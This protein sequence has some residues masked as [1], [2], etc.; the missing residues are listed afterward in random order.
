MLTNFGNWFLGMLR[1]P[2]GEMWVASQAE[3]QHYVNGSITTYDQG[4]TPWG[5]VRDFRMDLDPSGQLWGITTSNELMLFDGQSYPT[6][7]LDSLGFEPDTTS[8]MAIDDN[9]DLYI[10]NRSGVAQFSLPTN[11]ALADTVWPGDANDDLIANHMDFL[12]LGMAFG[13]SGPARPN[14]TIN[15]QAEPATTW[16]STLPN[17]AN[18]VHCDTDGDGVVDYSDTLAILNNYGLTHNKSGGI[19]QSGATPL[20]IVPDFSTYQAGDTVD[21]PIILGIDT[22]TADSVYGLAFTISYD[23][24]LVDSASVQVDFGNSWLGDKNQD[25]LSM[26]RDDFN[27]GQVEIALTRNDQVER[28]GFGQIAKI[29]VIMIDDVS[30]KDLI[31]DTLRMEISNVRLIRRDDTDIPYDTEIAEIEVTQE[32]TSL[33]DLGAEDWLIFPNPAQDMLIVEAKRSAKRQSNIR[34]YNLQGQ[35]LLQQTIT[36]DQ[37]RLDLTALPNALYILQIENE[38]GVYRQKVQLRRF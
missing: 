5:N 36:G 7:N 15:W 10:S 22:L 3:L 14:A 6:Y 27:N 29:R 37:A 33:G 31:R 2:Q 30:G 20:L 25:M 21:A 12:A 32:V 34:L 38:A 16:A 23:V 11:P 8:Y 26:A 4:S 24:T 19:E 9:G 13:S 18:Y 1:G 35:L 28:S 17:G